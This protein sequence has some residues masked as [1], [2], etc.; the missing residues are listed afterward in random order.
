MSNWQETCT[1]QL[2]RL[3]KTAI[4]AD[5][6]VTLCSKAQAELSPKIISET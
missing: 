2:V 4:L 6:L 3:D 5:K 1:Q